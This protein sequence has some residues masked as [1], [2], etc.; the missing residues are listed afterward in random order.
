MDR[1][2]PLFNR[3]SPSARVFHVGKT[4]QL[5]SFEEA[6]GVGHIHLLRSGQLRV[7]GKDLEER[8][9]SEATVIFSPKPQSHRL[10][11][12]HASGVD[13]VCASVDMGN[14]LQNPF[15]TA[16]PPLMIIP[17]SEVPQLFSRIEWLFIE[18]EGQ[19][20]G[21]DAALDS[22]IEYILV[23]LMRHAMDANHTS[24]C[25]LSGLSDERLARAITAIH[26]H[27]EKPWTL[28]SLAAQASMSRSRF[29]H[30]FREAVGTTALDY[31]TDWRIGVAR[32]LLR[33]GES[34]DNV[35][36]QVGYTDASAFSR[37]FKRRSGQT[38]R[39][40]LGE[41]SKPIA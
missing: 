23:L 37:T 15:I 7:S 28:E 41:M 31:L 11:P 34:I 3:F 40:W 16:L 8:V 33:N 17:L 10:S 36:R 25:I 20:C 21:R 1:L 2:S 19:A 4:C 13:L 12:V 30:H 26:E 5:S 29:A 6:D 14:E 18:A 9:L 35:A 39:D 32:S 38:P 24:S 22:L 27:P